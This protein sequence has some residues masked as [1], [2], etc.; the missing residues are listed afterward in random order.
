LIEPKTCVRHISIPTT[1]FFS[2]SPKNKVGVPLYSAFLTFDQ[3]LQKHAK[4]AGLSP[5][6]EI[7]KA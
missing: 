5:I 7:P 4:T 2:T 1:L 6:V 3:C